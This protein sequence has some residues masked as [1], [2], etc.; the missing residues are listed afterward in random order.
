[1]DP[2]RL[3]DRLERAV[4]LAGDDA[5]VRVVAVYG[6]Q[7]GAVAKVFPPTYM[8]RD[9]TRYH[10][11]RRWG[12]DGQLR[13]VVILDSVQSQANR[14]EAA[15]LAR[16]GELGLPQL[17][18]EVVLEDRTVR[19]SSLQAPHRSRDAYFLDALL[20][21]V[22]FDKTEIGAALNG[23]TTDDA[24]AYLR[25]APCD[26]VY[27]VWDS[28]RGKR[29]PVKFPRVYTSEML[30]W[31]PDS[32]RRAATKGDPLNLP[33]NSSVPVAEW[34]PGMTS[35]QG[36]RSEQRLSELGHGM[37]PGEASDEAGGVTVRTITRQGVLSLTGLANLR[38]RAGD[39]DVSAVG[40]AALAA[41]A[42]AGDRLA[43][44]RA[45][46][47]LRSGS[48]LVLVDDRLE[49]VQAGGRTE[50]LELD[51]DGAVSLLQAASERLAQAGV[52]WSSEPVVLEPK[53]KLREVI[54]E[55]FYV[56]E[57]NAQS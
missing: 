24:T 52:S 12:Q 46:I 38:F 30:G 47:H 26:L 20:D 31:D 39:G 7:A 18:L 57:L 42:L 50:P 4:S 34:R 56:P 49:W 27:G 6:P 15:L 17:V 11:E 1:M 22:P 35:K 37:V 36:K 55:T 45:G 33:G 44:A 8:E 43:F 32:G 54:E 53:P 51:L 13:G 5:A 9:G 14:A 21:G 3:L 25:Y 16:A 2:E 28:H 10:F 29:L 40:G 23:V 48:D 19:I 41:L